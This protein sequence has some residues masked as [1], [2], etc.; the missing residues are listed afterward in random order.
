VPP[1][2]FL[3][4]PARSD[5]KR[6]GMLLRRGADFDLARRLRSREGAAI[7]D[8]F[9]FASGLY[10][11]GKLAYARAV[12]AGAAGACEVFV[13]VP[14]RGLMR[15]E[16]RVRRDDLLA[17]GRVAVDAADP[18][19]RAPFEVAVRAL[20]KGLGPLDVVVLLGSIASAKYVDVLEPLLGAR[21]RFPR[22]FVG[23]GDMSRGGLLLRCAR[24]ARELEYVP[25][26]GSVRT[27]PR[28]P[29]LARVP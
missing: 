16:D 26:A 28:P 2:A 13:I 9:A 23:R 19:F 18:A 11:R 21:L 14:G 15:P 8:V 24:E 7:G 25:V 1:R 5:G 3:L 29:R 27:G 22:D 10:F 20:S 17:F 4:S 6:A 12:A